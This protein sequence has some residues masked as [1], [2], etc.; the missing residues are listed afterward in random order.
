MNTRKVTI[1]GLLT[2]VA[3]VLGYF[4]QFIPIASTLPGIKLGLANTVL[5]YAIYMMSSKNSFSL[6]FLKVIL[7]G[8][9]F[10]GLSSTIYSFAGGL[11]SLIMMLIIKRLPG[12]SIIGVSIVGAVFHNAGQILAAAMI[13]QNMGVFLYLPVLLISAV[14]TGILTGIIAKYVLRGLSINIQSIDKGIEMK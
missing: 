14:I 13:V 3:L 5:L 4:E 9:L 6:M 12:V 2:G 7:S 8:L 1:F 11:L 10:A